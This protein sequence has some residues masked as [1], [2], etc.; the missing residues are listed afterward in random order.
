MQGILSFHKSVQGYSHVLKGTPCEDSS[1]SYSDETGRFHIAVIADGHGDPKCT[2]SSFGS[3]T[4]AN[5]AC[6]SLKEF[7]E[8]KLESEIVLAQFMND[9]ADNDRYEKLSIRELTDNILEC[10]RKAVLEDY[11]NNPLSQEEL[12][13]IG[14][15]PSKDT[16]RLHIY[17]TTLMAG[18]LLRGKT[19]DEDTLAKMPRGASLIDGKIHLPD[20]L[21]LIHQGDGRCDLFNADQTIEQPIPWDDRCD[22]NV[23]TSICEPDADISIRHSVRLFPASHKFAAVFLGSDGVE[24]GFRDTYVDRGGAHILMGG[25]HTFYKNMICKIIDGTDATFNKYLDENLSEFSAKGIFGAPGSADDVSVAGIVDPD[26]IAGFSESFSKDV[27]RYTFEEQL[28]WIEDD[29][30]GKTRKHEILYKRQNNAEEKTK[31]IL[32]QKDQLIKQL[33]DMDNARDCIVKEIH[34]I[35]DEIDHAQWLLGETRKRQNSDTTFWEAAYSFF[36]NLD[37]QFSVG[38]IQTLI[39]SLV[40]NCRNKRIQYND[41]EQTIKGTKDKLQVIEEEYKNVNEAKLQAQ[42]EYLEYD[43]I[44]QELLTQKEKVATLLEQLQ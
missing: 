17:G 39:D 13:V 16:E 23:T 34:A 1:A 18:I 24:D 28:F 19:L 31:E 7:A 21:I 14:S 36:P 5:V 11:N 10:W 29:L 20:C 41:L 12:Q 38:V 42:H 2:R 26:V 37:S 35:E 30:R 33:G 40:N 15:N 9:I 8:K 22:A 4:A 27:E 25:V 44:F 3:A 43:N 32:L 6:E